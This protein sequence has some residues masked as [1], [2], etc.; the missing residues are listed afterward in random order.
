MIFFDLVGDNT[1]EEASYHES[2]LMDVEGIDNVEKRLVK[3][4]QTMDE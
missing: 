4:D 1:E 3:M 2:W